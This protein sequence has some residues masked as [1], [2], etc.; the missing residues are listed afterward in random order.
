MRMSDRM[1]A[2]KIKDTSQE[3]IEASS[4]TLDTQFPPGFKV[5]KTKLRKIVVPGAEEL[6]AKYSAYD[7]SEPNLCASSVERGIWLARYNLAPPQTAG[8][9]LGISGLHFY[10]NTNATT[11]R[12][13]R[14]VVRPVRMPPLPAHPAIGRAA[15]PRIST[16]SLAHGRRARRT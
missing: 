13:L 7:G 1:K 2:D 9:P 14:P 3:R 4:V 8:R 15:R 16:S 11:G 12:V 6:A 5:D 10:L